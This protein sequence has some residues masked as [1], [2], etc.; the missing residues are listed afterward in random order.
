M[1]LKKFSRTDDKTN[2]A[3][4]GLSDIANEV[5]VLTAAKSKR[6]NTPMTIDCKSQAF[7]LCDDVEIEQVLVNLVN[8]SID[9]VKTASHERW[10]KVSIFDEDSSVVLQVM[11]SGPGIPE[12][13]RNKLFDPFFTTKEV[14]K[15]T[16]LGLS[17]SK[18]ILDE[19][20]ATINVVA[21]CPN[22]CFEIRFRKKGR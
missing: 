19:H 9:A 1:S 6:H 13:V 14:G 17:I 8:N 22:T 4:H 7:I 2:F 21:N 3:L 11:D 18:G 12:N 5:A 16:G 15:G 10:V 20:S